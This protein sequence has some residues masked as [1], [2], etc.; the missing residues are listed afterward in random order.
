MPEGR[1]ITNGGFT[2]EYFIKDHLGNTRAVVNQAGKLTETDNYYPFG[3]RIE[4]L[5]SSVAQPE[6]QYLYNGKELQEDFGLDWYDY[7]ARF[8]DAQIGRWHVVDPMAE[9]RSWLSPYQYAQNNPINLIDP[10]GALDTW[11]VTGESDVLLN[12]NDGSN[13]IVTVPDEYVSTFKYFADSYSSRGEGSEYE[14]QAW[15]DHWKSE[16]GLADKQLSDKQIAH[17]GMLNSDWSRENAVE[18]WLNPTI[19]NSIAAS[20]SEALSQLTNPYLVTAGAS[21]AVSSLS[22]GGGYKGGAYKDL[23]V[24]PGQHRHHIPAN[25]VSNTSKGK[26]GAIV[27]EGADHMKT[28]SWGRSRAAQAYRAKQGKLIKNGNT[29]AAIEMDIKDIRSK[30]GNK[31]N[32]PIKDLKKYYDSQ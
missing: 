6:N 16:F 11:Y 1:I 9:E 26:G 2:C 21:I 27:M 24:K 17:L 31:Y 10:D 25:S 23:K 15:N 4:A 32:S 19:W 28:A 3:M 5:S 8:Y 20:G 13:D 7:G 22:S 29:R 14:L 12:T 30:F 18:Y